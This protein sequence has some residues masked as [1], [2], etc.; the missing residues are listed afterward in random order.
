MMSPIRIAS[1]SGQR[2]KAGNDVEQF[3]ID[4]ALAQAVK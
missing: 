2:F 3:F 4:A 1:G